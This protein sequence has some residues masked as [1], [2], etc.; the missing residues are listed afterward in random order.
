MVKLDLYKTLKKTIYWLQY[1]SEIYLKIDVITISYHIRIGKKR[2]S[3]ISETKRN[4]S[5]SG[6]TSLIWLSK[7]YFTFLTSI[8]YSFRNYPP[9]QFKQKVS[10][11]TFTFE[12]SKVCSKRALK[13]SFG[14]FKQSV[15]YVKVLNE[16]KKSFN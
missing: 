5:I 10:L 3:N 15:S 1:L 7:E 6:V 12:Q 8:H 4:L 9:I 2:Y 13:Y 11:R 14:S 16:S